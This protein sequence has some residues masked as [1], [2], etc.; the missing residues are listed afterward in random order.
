MIEAFEE[1]M[2]KSLKEIQENPVKQRSLKRKQMNPL[3]TYRNI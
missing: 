2:Y 3:Q 1:K